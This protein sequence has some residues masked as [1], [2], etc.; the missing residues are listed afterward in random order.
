M[1]PGCCTDNVNPTQKVT[2]YCTVAWGN[3]YI[4][5]KNIEL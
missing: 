5:R 2:F 1:L 4:F 3:M